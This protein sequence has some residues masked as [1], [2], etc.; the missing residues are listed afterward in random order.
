[1]DFVKIYFLIS[2]LTINTVKKL[3]IR[4]YVEAMKNTGRRFWP[5]LRTSEPDRNK[6]QNEDVRF[7]YSMLQYCT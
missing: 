7:S 2:M 4:Q 5:F 1:M 6:T 3:I